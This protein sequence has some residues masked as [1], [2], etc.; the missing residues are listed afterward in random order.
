VWLYFSVIAII[1]AF[2]VIGTLVFK[3]KDDISYQ[4]LLRSLDEI[5]AQC[6]Y[7][8][9]MAEGTSLPI[10]VTLPG[11]AYLYTN[12]HRFCSI[13]DEKVDCIPCNCEF[14]EYVMELNTT[15]AKEVLTSHRYTCF[16]VRTENG[17]Q[18]DCQG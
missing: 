17:V 12:D 14:N 5:K 3:N 18:I 4:H 10:D 6:D 9:N 8:C 7:V 11:G 15:I 13:W 16:F 1:I 2:G